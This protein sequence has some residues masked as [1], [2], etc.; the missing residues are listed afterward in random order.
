[1][2]AG[3]EEALSA[4]ALNLRERG[5]SLPAP[6]HS[7]GTV[8]RVG[9]GQS[10]LLSKRRNIDGASSASGTVERIGEAVRQ[11]GCRP[12][13]QVALGRPDL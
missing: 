11:F 4:Y 7:A 2:A 12:R 1:M 13:V 10:R 8:A 3:I 6:H 9:A 5:V